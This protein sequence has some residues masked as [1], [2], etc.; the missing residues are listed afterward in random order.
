ML[1]AAR[2]LLARKGRVTSALL[3]V[4]PDTASARQYIERFGSLGRLYDLIGYQPS[5][6]QRLS[7][8]RGVGKSR[9]PG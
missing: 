1:D 7:L 2:A 3:D 6:R 5:G 9:R 4:A 8:E